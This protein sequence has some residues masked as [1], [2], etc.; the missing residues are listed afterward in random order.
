[1]SELK[2]DLSLLNKIIKELNDQLALAEKVKESDPTN[3]HAYVA[4]LAKC[5]GL[6]STVAVEATALSHDYMKLIKINS[7]PAGALTGALGGGGV[8]DLF[9]DLFSPKKKN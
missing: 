7:V 8:D 2:V 4:E 5:M 3:N 1:M 9:G 6:V